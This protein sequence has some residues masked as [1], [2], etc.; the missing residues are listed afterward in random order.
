L[1]NVVDWAKFWLVVFPGST[2]LYS[3]EIFKSNESTGKTLSAYFRGTV[4]GLRTP[5]LQPPA[6]KVA[7]KTALAS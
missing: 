5:L 2:V 1:P 4:D 3:W 7:E 6:A